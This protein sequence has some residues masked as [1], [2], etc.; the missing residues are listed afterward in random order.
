MLKE[1]EGCAAQGKPVN[2]QLNR[3]TFD[4]AMADVIADYTAN[5]RNSLRDPELRT[6]LHLLPFFGG[7]RLVHIDDAL[8]RQYIVR[9]QGAGAS[10]ATINRE[11]EHVRRAFVLARVPSRPMFPKLKESDPRSNF[12]DG[13]RLPGDRGGARGARAPR[14]GR[15]VRVRISRRC[16][17]AGTRPTRRG[18]GSSSTCRTARYSAA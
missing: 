3:L 1:R 2:V 14:D 8:V 11:L 7:R 13:R 18:R 6:R 4:A 5:G 9:R 16:Y 15:S 10:N 17:G 12:V